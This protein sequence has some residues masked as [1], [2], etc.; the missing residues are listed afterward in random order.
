MGKSDNAK[1]NAKNSCLSILGMNVLFL[2]G[3]NDICIKYNIAAF[4]FR[5]K[6]L[7]AHYTVV[8]GPSLKTS[9]EVFRRDEG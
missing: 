7:K 5:C 1:H 6:G 3:R 2:P 9:V 8:F 4:R